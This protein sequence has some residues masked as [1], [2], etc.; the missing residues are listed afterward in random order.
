MELALNRGVDI[1]QPNLHGETALSR[2]ALTGTPQIIDF[3]LSNGAVV[4]QT[5]E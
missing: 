5:N 2:A 4:N 1:N 3:L